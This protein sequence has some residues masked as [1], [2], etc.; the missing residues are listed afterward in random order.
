VLRRIV[1]AF[2]YSPPLEANKEVT[3]ESSSYSQ[4]LEKNRAKRCTVDLVELEHKWRAKAEA[5]LAELLK[6]Q[7]KYDEFKALPLIVLAR[8]N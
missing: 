6:A 2:T 3:E 5:Q 1:L 8:L 7:A 4:W